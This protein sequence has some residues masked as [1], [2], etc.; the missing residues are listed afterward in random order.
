MLLYHH[1]KEVGQIR[2][3]ISDNLG[4]EN[5]AVFDSLWVGKN[6]ERAVQIA[7]MQSFMNKGR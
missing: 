2:K 4:K 7:Q 1:E 5:L 3:F 6:D